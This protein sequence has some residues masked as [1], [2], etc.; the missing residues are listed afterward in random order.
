[1][2]AFLWVEGAPLSNAECERK[3]KSVIPHRKG[4]LF[5]KNIVGAFVGDGLMSVMQTCEAAMA[6]PFHY[7]TTICG[8][9]D[10]VAANPEAGLPWNYEQN[11]V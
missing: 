2:T 9:R 10:A 4:S 7:L 8:H 11:L 3:I 5:Y 6:S 1:L